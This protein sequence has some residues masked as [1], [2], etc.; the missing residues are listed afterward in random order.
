MSND[1]FTVSKMLVFLL[2]RGVDC[3]KLAV[4]IGQRR[5]FKI[6]RY[7]C[8][9]E[10]DVCNTLYFVIVDSLCSLFFLRTNLMLQLLHLSI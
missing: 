2:Y 9:L 3:G 7:K 10:L 1:I 5:K 4:R 6:R 8:Y